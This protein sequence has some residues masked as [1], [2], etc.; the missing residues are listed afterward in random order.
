M[1]RFYNEENHSIKYGMGCYESK[2]GYRKV[3]PIW[4]LLYTLGIIS[5]EKAISKIKD[6]CTFSMIAA[7]EIRLTN[8]IDNRKM[9]YL[10]K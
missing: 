5:K 7:E 4:V 2:Q 8:L 3:N 10:N 6:K 9:K 1:K